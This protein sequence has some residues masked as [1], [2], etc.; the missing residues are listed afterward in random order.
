[1]DGNPYNKWHIAPSSIE[2]K[3]VFTSKHM[4][5]NEIIG[6]AVRYIYGIIPKITSDFG[7]MINH[8]YRPSARIEYDS[9]DHVWVLRTYTNL[10]KNTEITVDYRDTPWF[11][12]G[13]EEWYK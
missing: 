2:G 5:K 4:R 9:S 12:E 11:I 10:K 7:W 6:V 13:P 3:G 1:M 8:S